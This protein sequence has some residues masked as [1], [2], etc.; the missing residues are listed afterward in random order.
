MHR[1]GQLTAGKRQ[2][3]GCGGLVPTAI[4]EQNMRDP[5]P[6]ALLVFA[7]AIGLS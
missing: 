3:F 5:Q 6:E 1:A 7:N 4:I 2:E